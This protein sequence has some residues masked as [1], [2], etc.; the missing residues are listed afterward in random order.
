MAEPIVL[1]ERKGFWIEE[2][3]LRQAQLGERFQVVVDPGEIRILP[4]RTVT[5]TLPYGAT[6]DEA[7]TVLAEVRAEVTALYGGQA[8]PPDQPYF[9]DL[10]WREYQALSEEQRRVL[11]DRIYADFNLEIETVE[12]RDVRPDT[13]VAG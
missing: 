13:L 7:R 4:E 12:E 11:W 6:E 3:L 5:A 10:T 2:R 9:G 8:P 1:A